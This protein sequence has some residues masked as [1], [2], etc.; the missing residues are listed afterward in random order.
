MLWKYSYHI[1]FSLFIIILLTVVFNY[2]RLNS[3]E[4]E[5]R[6]EYYETLNVEKGYKDLIW[7]LVNEKDLDR[8]TFEK[9]FYSFKDKEIDKLFENRNISEVS[10]KSKFHRLDSLRN[11]V[12]DI[13]NKRYSIKDEREKLIR[14]T[15]R[16]GYIENANKL[17]N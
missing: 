4:K 10:Y 8:E 5:L 11:V 13:R 12:R 15:F 16:R 1:F 7:I 14:G 3:K 6:E 17:T 9:L 2:F